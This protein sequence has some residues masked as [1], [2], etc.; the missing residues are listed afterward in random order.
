MENVKIFVITHKK[1]EEKLNKVCIPIQVGFN[2]NLGFIRDNTG[3]N[4]S[5]KNRNYCELTGMYWIWKNCKLPEYIG[6]CHYRR[7]FV[8]GKI[9]KKKIDEKKVKEYFK[10]C[11][12]IL[13]KKFKFDTTVWKNYF[14]NGQGKEKDLINTKEILKN[15]YPEYLKSFEEVMDRKEGYYCNMFIMKNIGFKRY[16][17]WLFDILFELE[18]IT[19]LTN[20]T[21]QEAR[22][23]GY[24]SELLL[25][26][27]V[28]K[29][30]LKIKECEV[31]NTEKKIIY[32]I[33]RKLRKI[34]KGN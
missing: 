33:K 23:Y 14:E 28:E 4:I 18:K 31:Q 15:K 7:F 17:E 16:C 1:I 20:Y 11:D 22:I 27:W 30:E 34:L 32:R 8:C 2:E 5:K 19:D 24:I 10:E 9:I 21:P 12:I 13:P 6:L 3:D 26:V 25:N 29:N